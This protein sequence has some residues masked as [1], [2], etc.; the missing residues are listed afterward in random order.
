MRVCIATP[1]PAGSRAGNRV[2]ALRWARILRDLGHQVVLQQEYRG[3]RCDLLVALHAGRSYPS[4]ERFRRLHPDSP[5]V[6]ALTGTDLYEGIRTSPLAR[7]SLELATRLVVLQPL[8]VAE[9]PESVREKARVIYQSAGRPRPRPPVNAQAFPVCVLGHLRQVKDPFRTAL[10]ARLLPPTSRISVLHVGAALSAEMKEQARGE[11]DRNPR[12]RWLGE[13][14]RWKA[15][16]ILGQCR[17]LALT[18]RMEG[19]AN[20]VSEAL[21]AS[22]PIVASRI[23]GT[24]GILGEG[25][26]GYFEAGD[27]KGLSVL[28]ARAE[29]DA[30]FYCTL[31]AWCERLQPLVEPARERRSWETLLKELDAEPER[32]A[33]IDAGEEQDR[34]AFARDVR[35]GLTRSPK[36]LP[37]RYFYDPQGSRLFEE[38]CE[39]PEY[40]LPAAERQILQARA[41]EIASLLSPGTVLVELGSGSAAKTRILIGALLRRQETLRYVPV[42]ISRA[43]LRES[44]RGLLREYPGLEIVAVAGDYEEGLG[45]LKSL[46]PGPMLVLWLGSNIGNLDRAEAVAFLR[47]IRVL[48]SPGDRIL[49]GIDLR[50]ESALLEKAYDDARGV[51]ARF[52]LNLLARINRELGGNFPVEAFHHWALYD[53]EAGRVE[54]RLV[55]TRAQRVWIQRLGF[56]V[57]FEAGETIH[58]ED[59]YKYSVPEIEALAAAAGLRVERRW[60]D[61]GH[62][63][64]VNLFAL[65]KPPP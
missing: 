40:Y 51:T 36:S 50:K 52:N 65:P 48:M 9:L 43:A 54:M 41:G 8:G 55:S 37:C 61:E 6:V 30:K 17:L 21:A 15:L 19:G 25:Y 60:L 45:R 13:Q 14:P 26:P 23:P 44:C 39:L 47:R 32:F 1:A 57:R 16:R 29:G 49:V 4:V 11:A 2:T 24:V 22:V 27:T 35:D 18:S 46:V 56:E 5:L 34:A 42:D 64:S 12:Y 33:L 58:T 7:R 28:L 31:Q 63:F 53:P 59:S 10:A 3:G 62:L 38:I 20:V